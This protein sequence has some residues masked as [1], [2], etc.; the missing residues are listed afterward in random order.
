MLT[1]VPERNHGDATFFPITGRFWVHWRQAGAAN[2]HFWR[3]F[4]THYD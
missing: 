1:S 2:V 4:S 3:V